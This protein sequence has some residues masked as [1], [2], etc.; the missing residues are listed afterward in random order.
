M[1]RCTSSLVLLC[2]GVAGCPKSAPPSGV[3]AGG[4][5]RTMPA[6]L[7]PSE[8]VLPPVTQATLS[9]GLTVVV[10]ENREIPLFDA[11]LA[12]RIP[13]D[14]DPEG[15]EGLTS[16][17]FS[18]MDEGAG[19]RD[20]AA[21]GRE[22]KRLGGRL[23]SGSGRDLAYVTVGGPVRNLND[24]L[25]LWADVLLRPA[26]DE[27]EWEVLKTRRIAELR[28]S[29]EDPNQVAARVANRIRFGEGYAGRQASLDSLAAVQLEELRA[30][31]GRLVRPDQAI[32]FIGGDV[33]LDEVTPLLEQQFAAWNTPD[34]PPP[35]APKGATQAPAEETIFVVDQPG[36]AQAVLRAYLEVPDRSDEV[37]WPLTMANTAFG[38][39]FTARVNMDLREDKGW[40]YGARCG[41]DDHAGSASWYC[42]TNVQIDKTGPS[43]GV[44]RDLLAQ[45]LDTQPISADELSYFQGYLI[46]SFYGSYETPARLL[47]ELADQWLHGLPPDWLERYVPSLQGLS[48]DAVNDAWRSHIQPGQLTWLVVG[49]LTTV[50]PQLE[51]LDLPIVVL[52]ADGHPTEPAP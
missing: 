15:R 44:I 18:L 2:L 10:V 13:E 31:H 45:S 49:D 6:S 7:T 22:L 27:A 21:L 12:L 41:L 16:L 35:P 17:L 29:Y 3:Q 42:A 46:N 39:A 34:A 37:W 4:V 5:S 50:Q 25:G 38:G 14:A 11:R 47:G 33:S 20:A 43:V 1:M 23:S 32:L 40:T 19:E 9:N 26:L 30:A 52:D 36:T 51:T 8:F 24:L 28:A 48:V